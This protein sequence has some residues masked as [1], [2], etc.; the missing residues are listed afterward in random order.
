MKAVFE[1]IPD[2]ARLWVY[3]A[4]R[5]LDDEEVEKV[6][7]AASKFVESW[8]AHGNALRSSFKVLHHQF[9]VLTVDENFNGASGC[10]IDSSVGLIRFLQESLGINFLDRSKV[11]HLEGG[12]VKL[13]PFTEL[14]SLVNEGLIKRDTMI[15]DN[16]IDS[17]LKFRKSWLTK[18]E[19]SWLKRYFK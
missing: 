13:A 14:K 19:D 12:E 3:Q 4:D 11:A 15:F 8:E 18:A 10:S 7:K 9:L 6:E 16:S 2:T 17:M 5:Q 1:E